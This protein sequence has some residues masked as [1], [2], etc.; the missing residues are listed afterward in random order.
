MGCTAAGGCCCCCCCCCCLCTAA[1]M[2]LK[3]R[4]AVMLISCVTY[5]TGVENNELPG[6]VLGARVSLARVRPARRRRARSN[7]A[8]IS[9][10]ARG[11]LIRCNICPSAQVEEH[12]IMRA[13]VLRLC[14]ILKNWN[15]YW[16]ILPFLP[17]SVLEITLRTASFTFELS[18]SWRNLRI[19]PRDLRAHPGH[20]WAL[21]GTAGH[22]IS[23]GG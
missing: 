16:I 21:L 17:A 5:A 9:H 19:H 1:W 14:V 22:C 23:R 12:F 7:L 15:G 4:R 2:E 3:R 20:C 10:H 13:T 18:S 11:R 8:L 6:V